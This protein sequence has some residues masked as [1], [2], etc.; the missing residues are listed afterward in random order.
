MCRW[1]RRM[2]TRVI[3]RSTAVPSRRMPVP[4]SRTISDP[5][6]SRISTHEVFPP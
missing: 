3:E 2:S 5:A 1:V 4:A 6:P